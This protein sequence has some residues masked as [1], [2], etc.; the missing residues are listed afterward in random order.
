MGGARVRRLAWAAACVAIATVVVAVSPG[1][2]RAQ[3]SAAAG[4][5]VRGPGASAVE[6]VIAR[7]LASRGY[8]VA[9]GRG[10]GA[11]LRVTGSV[12]GSSGAVTVHLAVRA[13]RVLV[14]RVRARGASREAALDRV[15]ARLGPAI[16]T[17][18]AWAG[19]PRRRPGG[20]DGE[21]ASGDEGH[22]GAGAGAQDDDDD[23][24]ARGVDDAGAKAVAAPSSGIAAAATGSRT[25]SGSRAAPGPQP[26]SS[27]R[28]AAR[29]RPGARR[30]A[31]LADVESTGGAGG[32]ASAGADAT[33]DVSASAP[34]PG[35]RDS[36]GA[37]PWLSIAVG[38][39]LF[40]RHFSY[41]DDIF[42]Q[43]QEYDVTATP[44]VTATAAIYPMA[45]GTGGALAGLG[46]AGQF[47]HVPAFDSEDGAGGRYTSEARSYALGARYRH[48]L[49]GIEVAGALDYGS[50][51]FSIASAGDMPAPDFPGV[52]YRYLRA[53]LGIAAPLVSRFSIAAA[54]GYRQV[55]SSGEISGDDF[56]PRS[57]ARGF[58]ADLELSAALLW[59]FDLR[60]GAA[61][62]RYGHD[63]QPEPGDA[64]VA[65][66]ALDQYL[67]LFLRL[68]YTY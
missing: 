39:E 31:A 55:L 51:S 35:E 65:G 64:R 57:S 45:R 14:A 37:A 26:A 49:L 62:E 34:G 54:A 58:D 68:G 8:R 15:E 16:E 17:A 33:S 11:A 38:P 13:G 4:V 5:H 43:L 28:S 3:G 27:R 50:Q 56:F 20:G 9:T 12:S 24:E 53:G 23:D 30:T 25:P 21:G 52:S 48:H 46:L 40:G 61:L 41:R 44:A 2:A 42:H 67:R 47:T 36:A 66:G 63:L 29:R 60:V 7:V 1:A 32:R 10:R 22:R 19:G 18:V 59:G 6:R